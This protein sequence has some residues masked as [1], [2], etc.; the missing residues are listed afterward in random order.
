MV[1][2]Q[3]WSSL[4]FSSLCLFLGC[5]SLVQAQPASRVGT[6]PASLTQ[7]QPTSKVELT[8]K[9]RT[10]QAANYAQEKLFQWQKRLS[11]QDWN[12]TVQISRASELKPK[13]L[14]NI[15]WNLDKKSAII[16]VLDPADY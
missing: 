16:R 6:L 5:A 4:R 13:T 2:M 12:I 11:L 15:H 1:N 8:P 7:A 10:L 9:E 14:G 3:L